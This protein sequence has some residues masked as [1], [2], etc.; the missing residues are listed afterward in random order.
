MHKLI[1][2]AALVL[3][4][5][6]AYTQTANNEPVGGRTTETKPTTNTKPAPKSTTPKRTSTADKALSSPCGV[7]YKNRADMI[8]ESRLADKW[9]SLGQ[10]VNKRFW[11][12]PHRTTCDAKTSVLKSWIKEQHKNTDGDF[13]LV[14]YEMKCRSNQ[15]RVKTVIE[16]GSAGNVLETTNHEDDEP[17]Q[18]VA[19][20]TAG[21]TM[22][23]TAC[24]KQ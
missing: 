13:A 16:Y 23:R 21:E 3:A 4:A 1:L 6:T 12:N 14:L 7:Y 9:F 10:S 17:F 20:G 2:A 18:D 8:G 19:P 24:R 22:M 15:M 11:Y 5:T